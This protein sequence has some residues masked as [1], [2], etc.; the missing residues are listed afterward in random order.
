MAL[1]LNGSSDTQVITHAL[2]SAYTSMDS[3]PGSSTY[4]GVVK[5]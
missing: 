2:L 5:T 4:T 3:Y 1:W